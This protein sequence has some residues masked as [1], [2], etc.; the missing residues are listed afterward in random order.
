MNLLRKLW[1]L[2]AHK[3]DGYFDTNLGQWRCPECGTLWGGNE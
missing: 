1:C 3:S 2:L